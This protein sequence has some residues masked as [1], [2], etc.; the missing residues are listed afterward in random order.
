LRRPEA[1]AAVTPAERLRHGRA[2]RWRARGSRRAVSHA[3]PAG[4]P[5]V[6][7]GGGNDQS[8]VP[9]RPRPAWAS[10]WTGPDC[11]FGRAR[12]REQPDCWIVGPIAGSGPQL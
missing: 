12:D 2:R 11:D 1:T 9:R 3:Q 10:G 5:R 6:L 7:H 4:P 8:V